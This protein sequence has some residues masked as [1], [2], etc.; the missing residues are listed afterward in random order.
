VATSKGK[1][2][3]QIEF[4]GGDFSTLK[5]PSRLK[6]AELEAM[7][8]DGELKGAGMHFD[9]RSMERQMSLMSS[10]FEGYQP[11]WAPEVY[12]A[13][14]LIYDAWE[15]MDLE[16]RKRLAKKA[17]RISPDCAD[18]YVILAE[19]AGTYEKALAYYEKGVE[20]GRRALGEAFF[21]D[22]ENKGHFWGILETRPY[23]RAL[24]GQAFM[25]KGLERMAEAENLFR[26]LLEINPNDNQ[27]IRYELLY[28]LFEKGRY[29]DAS[30]LIKDYQGEGSIEWVYCRALLDF[31]FKGPMKGVERTLRKAIKHNH[32]VPIYLLGKKRIPVEENFVFGMGDEAEAEYYAGRYLNHWRRIP[33]AVAWLNTVYGEVLSKGK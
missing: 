28:D 21:L 1:I 5:R 12:I 26:S 4:P 18:A 17:L 22:E 13:Q 27:G 3:V 7:G 29:E 23:L 8:K 33:G 20:A 25:L 11:I 32:Y 6:H 15:L 9:R 2:P 24:S 10:S 31:Y 16:E 30:R 19:G 14:E